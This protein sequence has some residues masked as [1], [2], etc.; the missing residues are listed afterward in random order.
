VVL[1]ARAAPSKPNAGPPLRGTHYGIGLRPFDRAA[2]SRVRANRIE[3]AI[4]VASNTKG[5][6]MSNDNTKARPTHRIYSVTKNGDSK[7]NWQEIGAAWPH[8]DGKGFNLKFTARPLDG[9]EIV[10]RIATAKKEAA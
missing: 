6:T 2:F 3:A 8:K 5:N 4:G 7:A 9:A 10:L 1:H